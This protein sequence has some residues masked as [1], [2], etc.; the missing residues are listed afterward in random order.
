MKEMSADISCPIWATCEKPSYPR[1]GKC[2]TEY[3]GE[4]K[5]KDEQTTIGCLK[6]IGCEGGHQSRN[7]S[8]E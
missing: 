1:L 4:P 6:N 3:R 7:K 8:N 5:W 2:M